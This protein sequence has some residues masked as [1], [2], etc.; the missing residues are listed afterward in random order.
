MNKGQ[1]VRL[2]EDGLRYQAQGPG[3]PRRYRAAWEGRVGT[4]ARVVKHHSAQIQW[5]GNKSASDPVPLRFLELVVSTG[6]QGYSCP[7]GF[8]GDD[9]CRLIGCPRK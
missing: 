3:M 7:C 5:E 8:H 2:N 6:P 9:F 1:L 4:V